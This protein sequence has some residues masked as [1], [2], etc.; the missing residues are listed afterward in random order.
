MN[1]APISRAEGCPHHVR[2]EE[3]VDYQ[4]YEDEREAFRQAAMAIKAPRRIHLGDHLTFLFENHDTMRYQI[5]EIMRAEKIVREA[6]IAEELETYNGLLGGSGQ[7]GCALLI[8]IDDEAER[9]PLLEAWLGLQECLYAE[10][11]GGSRVRAEYDSSQVGRGRLSAVQY[12][13]FTL[14]EAPVRLGSDF[15]VLELSVGLDSETRTAMS[16]DLAATFI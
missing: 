13:K 2:R 4:T 16:A 14:P 5:Q 8:E 7:L 10:L 3:I 11:A 1:T 9:R 15:P 12:L 6:A